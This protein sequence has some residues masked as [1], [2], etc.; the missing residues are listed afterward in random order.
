VHTSKTA[1]E[2]FLERQLEEYL[3]VPCA[4]MVNSGSSA[5]LIA[6]A[7]AIE[8]SGMGKL[9]R[10]VDGLRRGDEVLVPALAWSTT[11]AP[12]VQLGARPVLVDVLPDTLNMDVSAASA[13]ITSEFGALHR[14]P[15][16]SMSIRYIPPPRGLVLT[17]QVCRLC[18]RAFF[19]RQDARHHAGARLG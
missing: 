5:N 3:H 6:V 1:R 12:L 17:T 11:L 18:M 13:K 15:F 2:K 9:G 14:A 16:W 10:G 7:G 4:V 8:L 19:C